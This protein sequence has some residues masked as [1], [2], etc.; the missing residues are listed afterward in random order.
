MTADRVAI[1]RCI[2]HAG[3]MVLL[4]AVVR[5][6]ATRIACSAMPPTALHPLARDGAVPSVA[7]AEYAA[8][9][10][11]VHGFL[12]DRPATPR[13][14]LLAKLTDVELATAWI[15]DDR[16]SVLVKAELLSR[17]A[18]G[19]LYD[20]EVA[21]DRTSIARGRLMVAFKQD[22]TQ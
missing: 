22:V 5:W 11:A 21:C 17:T 12:V 3:R 18:A 15:P 7:A 20:F 4:D 19:C 2:P 1:A 8:Q 16:G 9:A 14:G 6:D 10:A 13:Q